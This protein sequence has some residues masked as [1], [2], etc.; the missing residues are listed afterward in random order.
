MAILEY[1]KF[2]KIWGKADPI[3]PEPKDAK[4][5]LVRLKLK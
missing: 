2:L 4:E 1:E 5:R 3:Y